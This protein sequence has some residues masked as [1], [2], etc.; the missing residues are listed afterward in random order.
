MQNKNMDVLNPEDPKQNPVFYFIKP[1]E[2]FL[3][4][5]KTEFKT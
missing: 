2:V 3:K 1:Y 4:D 5:K